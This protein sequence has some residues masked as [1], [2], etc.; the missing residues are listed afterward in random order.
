MKKSNMLKKLLEKLNEKRIEIYSYLILNQNTSMSNGNVLVICYGGIGNAVSMIG[1]INH[2]IKTR[3]VTCMI[4]NKTTA[5]FFK[6]VY[7]DKI[8]IMTLSELTDEYHI[9]I[10]NF[11][12]CKKDVIK[13]MI[14][15]RIPHRICHI[16]KFKNVFNY[17]INWDEYEPEDMQNMNLLNPIIYYENYS[18]S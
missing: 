2:L 3:K 16:R 12:A 9:C 18:Q 5:I 7:S 4:P 13:K 1:V 6:Y 14:E 10:C 17:K 8:E 15:L 11:L